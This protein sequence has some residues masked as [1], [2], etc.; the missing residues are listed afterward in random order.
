MAGKPL[1]ELYDDSKR[2]E[3]WVAIEGGLNDLSN[4]IDT[5]PHRERWLF[6]T[7]SPAYADFVLCA[8]F[9]WTK[10]IGYEGAWERIKDLN[11]GKW[12]RLYESCEKY[13]PKSL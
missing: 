12:Q 10:A 5:L 6:G 9:C 1:E 4:F 7:D 13:M 8:S 11:G 2:D 3:T